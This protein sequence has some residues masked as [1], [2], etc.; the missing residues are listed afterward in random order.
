NLVDVVGHLH[1]AVGV[2]RPA[3][4]AVAED[5]VEGLGVGAVIG[6]GRGGVLGLMAGGNAHDTVA[7]GD[8]AFAA[9]G[10]S[11]GDAGRRRRLATQTAG[12]DFRLGVQD[13][14]IAHLSHHAAA[15]VQRPQRLGQVH[16]VV[17]LDGAGNR[18]RPDLLRLQS[19][20]VLVNQGGV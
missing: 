8:D 18:R 2:G 4:A 7:G 14:L 9:K 20:V 10:A 11:A 17:D 6:D 3:D 16:R 1:G 12:P 13:I 19:L 15:A 5:F